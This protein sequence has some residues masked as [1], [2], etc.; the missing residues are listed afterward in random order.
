MFVQVIDNSL[1]DISKI[2]V[3]TKKCIWGSKEWLSQDWRRAPGLPH[4]SNNPSPKMCAVGTLD[5]PCRCDGRAHSDES[6]ATHV[7]TCHTLAS[8]GDDC[9]GHQLHISYLLFIGFSEM[10]C[11]SRDLPMTLWLLRHAVVPQGSSAVILHTDRDMIAP[12]YSAAV[13]GRPSRPS[14]VLAAHCC[15]STRA[16][17]WGLNTITDH[18]EK[19]SWRIYLSRTNQSET[20]TTTQGTTSTTGNY[21]MLPEMRYS[22]G[23]ESQKSL[24]NIH[25][26]RNMRGD[27]TVRQ[28]NWTQ[29]RNSRDRN[30]RTK[31]KGIC[32]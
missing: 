21:R 6:S 5:P 3:K 1:K 2:E 18:S 25:Y 24:E 17:L 12:W 15:C 14:P 8:L 23:A 28:E 13:L 29:K 30:T 26:P 11:P 10:Y 4:M 22:R 19:I 20:E 32:R 27:E 9:E 31:G 7:R 16:V